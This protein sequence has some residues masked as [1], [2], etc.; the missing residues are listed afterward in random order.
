MDEQPGQP[1]SG[2]P[3]R[4]R[5]VTARAYAI[6]HEAGQPEG[7]AQEHWLRAEQEYDDYSG[8]VSTP[9]DLFNAAQNQAKAAQ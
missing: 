8:S 6:W 2:Q 9:D 1:A 3:A 4:E 5:T 7:K